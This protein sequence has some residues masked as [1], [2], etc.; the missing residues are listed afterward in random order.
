MGD[1]TD[2]SK[3]IKLEDATSSG[4]CPPLLPEEIVEDIL[5]RLPAKS[6]CR[7]RCVSR[8]FHAT[9]SSPAFEDAHYHQHNSGGRRRL[10]IRPP[11]D[12]EPFY[13]WHHPA[14]AAATGTGPAAETIMSAHRLPQGG[15]TFPVSTAS[16]RGLV[17]LKNTH[18]C[19]HHVWNPSTGEILA[20][21]D[22][23]PLRALSSGSSTSVHYGL[24]YCP[25]TR[26][27]KA[28]RV[29]DARGSYEVFTLGESA[30]WRPA[31]TEPPPCHPRENSRQGGVFCNGNLHFLDHGGGIVV[32]NVGDETFGRIDPPPEL[33][34][35]SRFELTELGGSLCIC[36]VMEK[37]YP[38]P[39]RL[40]DVWLLKGYTAAAAAA[41]NAKWEKLCR[42][43]HYAGAPDQVERWMML[44][45]YWITPL[46]M[47][48]DDASNQ[49]K[50][51]FGTDS[52]D[53]F[54]VDPDTGTTTKLALSWNVTAIG[55]RP[56][57]GFF[58]ESLA[59]VGTLSEN[60]AFASPSMR[61][62]S[63][64][65][66]RLPARTLLWDLNGVCKGWR[67]LIK[68]EHFAEAHLYRAN[69]NKSLRV[70]FFAG[71][72]LP[73]AFEPVEKYLNRPRPCTPPLVDSRRTIICS[74]PCHGL[75]VWSFA[76]HDIVCNPA[77]N[78]FMGLVPPDGHTS[79]WEG[80]T[81][82]DFLEAICSDMDYNIDDKMFTG[83]LGLGYEQ[84]SS[85]HVLV[86]LAYKERNLTTRDYK[87][88]CNMKYLK[89]VVWD[90]VDPPPRPI[91][92]MPPAHVNGKLNWMVD[93]ELGQKYQGLEIVELDVG[94]RKFEV[95]QGPPCGHDIG[96]HLSINELEEMVCVTHWHRATGI[97]TIWAM[98]D[99]AIWSVKYD[100]ELESFSPEYSPETTMPLV[101][102]P[103]DGR[104][105]LSTEK[106]LGYYNPKTTE[107]ETIYRLGKH[108]Q[109]MKFVPVLFQESLIN[110]CHS[111]V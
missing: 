28:V 54:V 23:V 91:A 90:E 29:Y 95:L 19:E 38:D 46:G 40:V 94:K 58:E 33:Q 15:S 16:C 67:A 89:D 72:G 24:C 34:S 12:Q 62:W 20:L 82:C 86:H 44:K 13:A 55:E 59:R 74:R 96:E 31:A 61:A 93:T 65:L 70:L 80:H 75:N 6:L 39:E 9:I 73:Y 99:D 4:G 14:A 92:N 47:Y 49:R 45:S 11:G 71:D 42:I 26:R 27:H 30:F 48:C 66:S 97:I 111:S 79:Y 32:F 52:C 100:I 103:K 50:I 17:L 101:V 1:A 76:D 51:V 3:R 21:P 110:P 60:A 81:A 25:A 53:V 84:E 87:M 2:T 78:Y 105:L 41:A 57:M 98:K 107:L 88:V 77:T 7:L 36:N 8:S 104:I 64:V 35:W 63:E 37:G 108:A 69:L 68:S 102:D 18:H 10:F 83:R 109:G 22:K 106:A 56:S 43:D 5:S 85:R